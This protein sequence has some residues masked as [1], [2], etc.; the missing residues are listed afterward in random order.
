MRILLSFLA[1]CFVVLATAQDAATL[2]SRARQYVDTLT[3]PA[4][5]GRGYVQNGQGIA[6]DFIAR[7]FARMGL[8]PVKDDYFQ[9][10]AF[11]V[12]SFPDSIGVRIDGTVL[13]P[14]VDYLVHP[15]SGRAEGR[16]DLVHL[17]PA[18]LFSS[19]RKAMTMGVVTGKAACLHWPDHQ[20]CRFAEAL[21]CVGTGTDAL[22]PGGE[23]ERG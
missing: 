19:E 14:G 23:G 2:T 13:Q 7:Q 22:R 21:R 1:G 4:F 10:F 16:Y 9:P 3:S 8:K 11:N 20:Q 5:H 6:A 12:N 18:D 17:T 15:A